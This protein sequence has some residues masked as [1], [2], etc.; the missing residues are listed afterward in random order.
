MNHKGGLQFTWWNLKTYGNSKTTSIWSLYNHHYE[1]N[2]L[3]FFFIYFARW[4]CGV[5]TRNEIEWRKSNESKKFDLNLKIG[6]LQ[7]FESIIIGSKRSMSCPHPFETP[8]TTVSTKVVSSSSCNLLLFAWVSF[9]E[10]NE[11]FLTG[12]TS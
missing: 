7:Q 11:L 3:I 2:I 9:S 12:I 5:K 10:Y 8:C 1:T 6:T 4:S